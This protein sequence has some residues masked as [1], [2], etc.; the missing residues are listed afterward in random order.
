M[1]TLWQEWLIKNM[2][3]KR[4]TFEQAQ[5]EAHQIQGLIGEKGTQEEYNEAEV[6]IEEERWQDPEYLEKRLEKG[7]VTIVRSTADE[8]IMIALQ[9]DDP[10]KYKRFNQ[11][12]SICTQRYNGFHLVGPD[13]DRGYTAWKLRRSPQDYSEI[14]RIIER[15]EGIME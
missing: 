12:A 2:C 9:T 7:L 5:D 10:D 14:P 4:Y 6:L 13:Q 3:P 11:V 8:G 15:I 1:A